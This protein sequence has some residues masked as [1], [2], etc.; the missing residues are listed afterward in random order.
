[1]PSQADWQQIPSTQARDRHSLLALQPTPSGER[2]GS[3][4]GPGGR[5]LGVGA[6]GPVGK[7]PPG[8]STPR[9]LEASA[10]T[11]ARLTTLVGPHAHAPKHATT[12]TTGQPGGPTTRNG[13]P[14]FR[15][16]APHL[17]PKPALVLAN[18]GQFAK[19]Q[20]KRGRFFPTTP[21][22]HLTQVTPAAS[23]R[24]REDLSTRA[25]LLGPARRQRRGRPRQAKIVREDPRGYSPGVRPRRTIGDSAGRSRGTMGTMDV[26]SGDL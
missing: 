15:R 7:P 5:L 17:T 14:R 10:S 18:E 3:T 19:R 6:S 8:A 2:I 23:T 9:P 26:S 1:M 4:G 21:P 13:D 24:G 16:Q 22:R 20:R 12:I 11:R 25:R